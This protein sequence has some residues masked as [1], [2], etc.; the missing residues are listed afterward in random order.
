MPKPVYM[1]CCQTGS[2]DVRTNFASHLNILDSLHLVAASKARDDEKLFAPYIPLRIVAVWS[3]DKPK[4]YDAEF[5][6]Q[7]GVKAPARI[8]ETIIHQGQFRF[9]SGKSKQRFTFDVQGF[10]PGGTGDVIVECRIRKLGESRWLRQTYTIEVDIL[11]GQGNN[12]AITR[13]N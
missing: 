10:N 4:D 2:D 1:L 5:E 12:S 3:I 9:E 7:V 6:V 11:N 8:K 13:G